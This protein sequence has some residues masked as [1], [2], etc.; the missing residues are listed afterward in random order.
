MKPNFVLTGK[1]INSELNKSL[2]YIWKRGDICLYIGTASKG[3]GRFL[4]GH[5]VIGNRYD[6]ED[7]DIIECYFCEPRDLAN[8]E[9]KLINQLL[10]VFNKRREL[11]L[12]PEMLKSLTQT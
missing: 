5:H 6:I 2:V 4:K 9:K 10:P 11:Q 3:V 8:L 7:D 1:V 12:P